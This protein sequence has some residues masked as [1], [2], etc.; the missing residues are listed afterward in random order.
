MS[1]WL[2]R[3]ASIPEYLRQGDRPGVRWDNPFRLVRSQDGASGRKVRTI[4]MTTEHYD[5]ANDRII[6]KGIDFE[7]YRTNPVIL[8][9]HDRGFDSTPAIG[10][11]PAQRIVTVEPGIEGVEFDM[12]FH[13][14][15]ALSAEVDALIEAEVIRTGSISV[16]PLEHKDDPITPEMEAEGIYPSWSNVRRTYTRSECLEGTICN[17]PMNPHALIQNSFGAEFDAR[18]RDAVARGVVASDGPLL[19]LLNSHLG[20]GRIIVNSGSHIANTHKSQQ[21]GQVDKEVVEKAGS[22]FSSDTK[23]RLSEEFIGPIKRLGKAARKLEQDLRDAV[24]EAEEE[25]KSV[26]RR[27]SRIERTVKD[28]TTI[29]KRK[30]LDDEDFEDEDLDDEDFEDEDLDDEDFED[31]DLDDEDFEDED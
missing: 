14:K 18:L 9:A 2:S 15:T 22:R 4:L 7:H 17:I 6:A 16:I 26:D 27:L 10:T 24:D 30:R 29:V 1:N 13:G 21:E 8:W 19:S 11:S 31:E 20:G 3:Y 12:I 23:K 25:Q 5:R 28:L